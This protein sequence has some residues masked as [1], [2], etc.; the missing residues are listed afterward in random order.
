MLIG[1]L[2]GSKAT[3]DLR[4]ILSKRLTVRGTVL[5]SRPLEE[6]I[7][8]IQAYEREVLPWLAS[9]RIVPRID[10]TFPL[11]EIGAAHALVEGNGT[12]GKVA[13]S[14]A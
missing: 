8:V 13:L 3:V 1:A 11:D 5:R 7:T 12:I 4:A 10:A 14:I 6:R 2:A 9:G